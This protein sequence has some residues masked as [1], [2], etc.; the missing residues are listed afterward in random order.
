VGA[1][2]GDGEDEAAEEGAAKVGA[3][4]DAAVDGRATASALAGGEQASAAAAQAVMAPRMVTRADIRPPCLDYQTFNASKFPNR[5]ILN[6]QVKYP[7]IS[8]TSR[9]RLIQE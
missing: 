6:A 9:G 7:D 1:A 5:Y 8:C 3:A 2:D 4:D